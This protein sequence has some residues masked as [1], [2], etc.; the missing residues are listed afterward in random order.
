MQAPISPKYSSCI[1]INRFPNYQKI[2]TLYEFF[3]HTLEIAPDREFY[4]KRVYENNSWQDK[5]EFIVVLNFQ[6]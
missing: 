1:L 5:F 4:G 6:K 3:S 2:S